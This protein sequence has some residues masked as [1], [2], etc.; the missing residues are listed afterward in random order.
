MGKSHKHHGVS[1]HRHLAGLTTLKPKNINASHNWSF[2]GEST[3]YRWIPLTKEPA[4]RKAFPWHEVI[5]KVSPDY[6]LL[7]LHRIISS[8]AT[9]RNTPSAFL[10]VPLRRVTIGPTTATTSLMRTPISW[11]SWR[12]RGHQ[13]PV[14]AWTISQSPGTTKARRGGDEMVN[15]SPMTFSN[16]FLNENFWISNIIP[17][18]YCF[19]W[20]NW[21][22]VSIGS[23]IGLA[24]NRR[25]TN[26]WSNDDPFHWRSE[27]KAGN[28]P[29]IWAV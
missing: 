23:D 10:S 27:L 1:N 8:L 18:K 21:Q 13:L 28:L 2:W 15:I 14:R 17:L 5:M 7:F 24:T 4:I 9:R 25:R 29:D 11:P 6:V 22:Y 3:G 20:S 26:V 12:T 19:L 16:I